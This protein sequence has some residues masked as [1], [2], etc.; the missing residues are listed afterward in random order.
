MC[1]KMEHTQKNTIEI[2]S[3]TSKLMAFNKC[4][5]VHSVCV[6]VPHRKSDFQCDEEIHRRHTMAC[7][8]NPLTSVVGR[9][10]HTSVRADS[11][12]LGA[13]A[14]VHGHCSLEQRIDLSAGID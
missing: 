7:P 11:G 1:L 2:T 8:T 4:G 10:E 12:V 9:M 6:P 5:H 14:T 3:D 13:R